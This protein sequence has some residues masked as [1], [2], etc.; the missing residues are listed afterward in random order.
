ML[1][2]PR[3]IMARTVLPAHPTPVLPSPNAIYPGVLRDGICPRREFDPVQS[4]QTCLGMSLRFGS[5][6][7]GE[8]LSSVRM[9]TVA[10]A[11]FSSFGETMT[12]GRVLAVSAP[13]AGSS[14]T[15]KTLK[16]SIT[17]PIPSH[18]IRWSTVAWRPA[19]PDCEE[20][21]GKICPTL[22]VPFDADAARNRL[23]TVSIPAHKATDSVPV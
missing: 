20:D 11:R 10:I 12:H 8:L 3:S 15:R 14:R 21:D 4:R 5:A 13:V 2:W 6:S 18:R 22:R 17:I 7:H 23:R 16:R 1:S 19:H 9:M